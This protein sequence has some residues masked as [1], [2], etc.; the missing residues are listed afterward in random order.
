MTVCSLA[1]G[2][3]AYNEEANIGKLLERIFSERLKNLKR[4]V[5]VAGGSDKTL[6]ICK[7]FS[8]KN[9]KV[10]V[11][12]DEGL[13][14]SSAMNKIMG[15]TDEDVILFISG[16]NLP[17]KGSMAKLLKKIDGKV[18]ASVGRPKPANRSRVEKAFWEMHHEATKVVPKL[19]G[20]L[21][22]AKREYLGRIPK[23][24]IND[25][26]YL[27]SV[28]KDKGKILYLPQ[29]VTIMRHEWDLKTYIRRRRRIARGFIQTRR[30][31]LDGGHI[32][33]VL[34]LKL[35][36]SSLRS[37]KIFS[38]AS[39]VFLEMFTISMAYFDTLRG[40]TPFNWRVTWKY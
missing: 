35:V 38:L 27:T 39:M 36:F 14:K 9:R 13:G 21:F 25:D 1:V 26:S 34:K 17:R 4:V 40:F 32:P 8:E 15:S 3:C 29:A 12:P 6:G 33:L 5:V 16:D 24:I 20:E 11:F 2:I 37:G 7:T 30:M 23:G 18:I 19:S 31:G 10:K 22:A 28:M